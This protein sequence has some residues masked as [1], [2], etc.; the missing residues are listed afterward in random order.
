MTIPRQE[1]N[2]RIKVLKDF[3]YNATRTP[4]HMDSFEIYHSFVT[5][6][7]ISEITLSKMYGVT[8]Y[9]EQEQINLV[10]EFMDC[11]VCEIG[12]GDE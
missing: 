5:E 1:I 8:E 10:S 2:R 3:Q 11:G 9:W 7:S 4:T 6:G 12:E